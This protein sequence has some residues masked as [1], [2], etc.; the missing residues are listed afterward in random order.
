MCFLWDQ[1][2]QITIGT[3]LPNKYGLL[4]WLH[5]FDCFPISVWLSSKNC[6]L[7][8][9]G[10]WEKMVILSQHYLYFTENFRI[11]WTTLLYTQQLNRIFVFHKSQELYLMK[12]W[13]FNCFLQIKIVEFSINPD[14]LML[15][16]KLLLLLI[17][18]VNLNR[19][20][21][22]WTIKFHIKAQDARLILCSPR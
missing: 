5:T 21:L 15:I 6:Y 13:H 2:K 11:I 22:L 4:N 18:P 3:L 8:N 14:L 20:Y 10:I 9:S 1:K 19:S 7:W 17:K 12:N 16:V